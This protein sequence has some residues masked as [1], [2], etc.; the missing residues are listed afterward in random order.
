MVLRNPSRLGH[1]T[2]GVNRISITVNQAIKMR[3]TDD[4][5]IFRR[6]ARS[7]WGTARRS[8]TNTIQNS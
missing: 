6:Y 4:V 5:E 1:L 3:E 2:R 7:R 8:F